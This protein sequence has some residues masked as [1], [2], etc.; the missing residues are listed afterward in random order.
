MNARARAAAPTTPC[1]GFARF[2]LAAVDLIRWG[3]VLAIVALG[4]SSLV[5][6]AIIAAAVGSAL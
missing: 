6:L 3:G 1:L 2:V 5:S 4:L